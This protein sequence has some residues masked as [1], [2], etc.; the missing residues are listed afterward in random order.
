MS[1]DQILDSVICINKFFHKDLVM[2][3]YNPREFSLF[4]SLT[5][6]ERKPP[7]ILESFFLEETR[8]NFSVAIGFLFL[9]LCFLLS[10][11]HHFTNTFVPLNNL[12]IL[13]LSFKAICRIRF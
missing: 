8:R 11:F 12:I 6:L 3:L 4:L 5:S 9:K 2:A 7:L 1:D 13:L 10:N